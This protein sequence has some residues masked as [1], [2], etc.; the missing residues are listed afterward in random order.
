MLQ[1]LI[2]E[3]I[4]SEIYFELTRICKI[5]FR[6]FEVLLYINMFHVRKRNVSTKHMSLFDR[7]RLILVILSGYIFLCLLPYNSSFEKK[8][9]APRSS[10]MRVEERRSYMQRFKEN[11]INTHTIQVRASPAFI[12]LC[13]CARHIYPCLVLVQ[14]GKTRPDIAENLL[15]GM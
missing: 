9:L 7:N 8:S 5:R 12:V 13:P 11:S 6:I 4:V 15:T 10:I 1:V 2:S 3:P 14:P